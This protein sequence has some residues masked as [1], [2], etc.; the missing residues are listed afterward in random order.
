MTDKEIPVTILQQSHKEDN[1]IDSLH[2]L[3]AMMHYV[4][5][6]VLRAALKRRMTNRQRD[7][8]MRMLNNMIGTVA[9]IRT[10]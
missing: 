10:E 4:D 8:L 3:K 7:G 2:R 6:A 1:F 5:N 9:N